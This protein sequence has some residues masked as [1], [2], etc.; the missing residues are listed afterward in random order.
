LP[1]RLRLGGK[2]DKLLGE[3]YGTEARFVSDILQEDP[4]LVCPIVEGLPYLEAE[5]VYA[6]RHELAC[7]VDDVL[8]R[9]IRARLMAR[10]ASGRAATRVGQIL[11]AELDL[12]TAETMQQVASY[13]AAIEHEKH[14]LMGTK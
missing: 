12:S 6:V 13:R 3:R 14:I 9:R 11:Q 1:F 10:D 2:P 5:V 4:S 8:S 7:T